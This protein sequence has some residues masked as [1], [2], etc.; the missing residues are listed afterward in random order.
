MTNEHITT[1]IKRPINIDNI[2]YYHPFL[3]P[4]CQELR[5]TR[6]SHMFH[7]THQG[8]RAYS[9]LLSVL[10]GKLFR[11]FGIFLSAIPFVRNN[12]DRNVCTKSSKPAINDKVLVPNT[13]AQPVRLV[14]GQYTI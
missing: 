3:N 2:I 13:Q 6:C 14:T 10:R 1:R 8:G 5:H 11:C 7:M 4:V 12:I 9:S